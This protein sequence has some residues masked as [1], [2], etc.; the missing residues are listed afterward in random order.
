MPAAPLPPSSPAT[1]APRRC[2]SA[3]CGP[4][5][6]PPPDSSAALDGRPSG[7]RFCGVRPERRQLPHPCPA[8][9]WKDGTR[10]RTAGEGRNTTCASRWPEVRGG[11]GHPHLRHAR[12]APARRERQGSGCRSRDAGD[13]AYGEVLPQERLLQNFGK[14]LPVMSY[15]D[16]KGDR[17]SPREPAVFCR[18][19]SSG[20]PGQ[21]PRCPP[22]AGGGTQERPAATAATRRLLPFPQAAGQPPPDRAGGL[23]LTPAHLSWAGLGEPPLSGWAEEGGLSR[24]EKPLASPAVPWHRCKERRPAP[25][26]GKAAA[27]R[28]S[29]ERAIQPG[30]P[31]A[32]TLRPAERVSAASPYPQ[33][34]KRPPGFAP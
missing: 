21:V 29:A 15:G 4:R 34:E 16:G 24:S 6:P 1:S 17:Q 3:P 13:F 10:N 7:T 8:P 22:A 27:V 28:G 26:S 32:T 18:P 30:N 25:A 31:A 2:L 14:L 23:G 11:G 12:P 20:W 5:R 33:A 19:R 9:P